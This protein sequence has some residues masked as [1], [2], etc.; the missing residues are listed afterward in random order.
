MKVS[1]G[2]N[3]AFGIPRI[4][5]A[6]KGIV[7]RGICLRLKYFATV[8][9]SVPR[10]AVNLWDAAQRIRVLHAAAVAM[11]FAD[12]TAFQHAPQVGRGL[13][14]TSVRTGFVNARVEG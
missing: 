9:Q 12:L 11:R 5:D 2:D 13:H 6:D 14:L 3:V 1:A 10:G 7:N 4:G 8:C